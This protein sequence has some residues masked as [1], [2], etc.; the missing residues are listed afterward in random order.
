MAAVAT[1]ESAFEA[2]TR[3]A[4]D[5]VQA[6]SAAAATPEA[7]LAPVVLNEPEANTVAEVAPVEEETAAPA[8]AQ[9]APET[10]AKDAQE[11]APAAT[12]ESEK[13]PVA[14]EGE[15][16]PSFFKRLCGCF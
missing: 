6:P 10:P 1:P 2:S 13:T 16:K 4:L 12:Q 15:R 5:K 7:P 3:E 9:K 14:V 11:S 8:L